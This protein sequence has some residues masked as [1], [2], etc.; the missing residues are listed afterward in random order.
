MTYDLAVIGGGAAGL[1]TAGGAA[2]L[3]LRVVLFEAGDM[4]GECLNT[5]CVPSKA[6]LAAAHAAHAGSASAPL[7]VRY[8]APDVDWSGVAAH[9][10]GAIAAIA[11]HD[12]QE[13]F[14]GFGIKV[15]RNDARFV[16]RDTLEAAGRR[17]RAR[18]IVVATGSAPAVPPIPGL[19]EAPYLTNE[20][21]F[22]LERRPDHLLIL[23]GG[24]IGCELAQA[25]RRLGSR[26]TLIE[27][28]RLLPRDDPEAVRIV[29]DSLRADGVDVVEAVKAVRVERSGGGVR[30]HLE[31]GR[32][33]DGSHLLVAAGRAPRVDGYGLDI[34]GVDH[35]RRGIKV[36]SRLRTTNRR[37]WAVG[38]CRDGPRFTHAAGYDAGIAI[39][40][41]VFRL[42]AKA[43]YRALPWVTYADPELAQVGP[44]ESDARERHGE[45]LRV[46]RWSFDRN[47]R[48]HAEGRTTGLAKVMVVGGRPIG[49]TIVGPAAGETIQLW[50]L[51]ISARMKLSAV[52]AM[53]APYPTYGEMA[54]AIAGSAFTDSLFSPRVRRLVG[55]LR[56]LP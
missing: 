13:R 50:A 38:D 6:L 20:T 16:A 24:A 10:A 56:R 45:A 41:I 40:N 3:G 17:Y 11:P 19:A 2:Q 42:P 5:G 34:A 53:I 7:G 44:T 4:G 21:I 27:A 12:S 28:D 15:V 49:A 26:V 1:V 48:A 30:L 43:D 52:A 23:G 8:A 33:V 32:A 25:H 9:V 31:D 36:D 54:K 51:A 29:A 55:L 39:R 35:D 37:I 14:E 47:D 46:L 22:G 18:R